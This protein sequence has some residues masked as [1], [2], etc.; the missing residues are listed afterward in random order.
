MTLFM[1]FMLAEVLLVEEPRLLRDFG[2]EYEDYR[3]RVSMFVPWRP[4]RRRP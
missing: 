1:A 4:R 3:Q 2:S